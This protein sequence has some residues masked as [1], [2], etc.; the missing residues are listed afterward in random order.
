M[1]SGGLDSSSISCVASRYLEE[2][3]KP[4][5]ETFSAVFPTIAE[6]D[7]RIDERK[8]IKSVVKHINCNPN[9]VEADSF[10]PLVD[11]DKL[12][13]HADHPVGAPNVF[14][15]WALFKAA[16]KQRCSRFVERIST[17]IRQFLT[18]TRLFKFSPDKDNGF[19]LLEVPSRLIKI[20]RI[21]ITNLRNLFGIEDLRKRPRKFARKFVAVLH[22]RPAKH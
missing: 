18:V 6:I 2:N 5:L 21:D 17:A 12:H 1:L 14:M 10:S 19:K 16:K 20:F 3:N 11:M 9:F 4:P 13:W 7:S 22:G 15:D 8:Y